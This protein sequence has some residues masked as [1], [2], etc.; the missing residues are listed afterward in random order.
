M[1]GIGSNQSL[2]ELLEKLWQNSAAAQFSGDGAGERGQNRRA[3][4]NGMEA[5][6]QRGA[7]LHLIMVAAS[8]DNQLASRAEPIRVT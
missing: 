8:L 5:D 4:W 7:P 2:S 6:R 1:T 3:N